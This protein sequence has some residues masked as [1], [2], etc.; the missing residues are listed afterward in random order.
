MFLSSLFKK[1]QMAFWHVS[2]KMGPYAPLVAMMLLGLVILSS[3]RLGLVLWK[4]DRVNATGKL[5]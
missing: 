5:L 3:S 1:W 4:L 2:K